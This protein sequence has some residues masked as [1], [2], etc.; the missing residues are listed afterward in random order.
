MRARIEELQLLYCRSI[1]QN[2]VAL[3]MA[4]ARIRT[5][6]ASVAKVL[7]SACVEGD[8]C[9]DSKRRKAPAFR[10]SSRHLLISISLCLVVSIRSQKE[11]RLLRTGLLYLFV[12]HFYLP[13]DYSAALSV[14]VR[15]HQSQF[16]AKCKYQLSR[17][18]KRCYDFVRID[19]FLFAL[20]YLCSSYGL[21]FLGYVCVY[22]VV[23]GSWSAD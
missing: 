10:S 19:T 2:D 14:C 9:L 6:L 18:Q 11:R 23:A 20:T 16:W 15:R 5:G 3:Q 8:G 17:R 7:H 12:G 13:P 4:T 21:R 22:T 1:L